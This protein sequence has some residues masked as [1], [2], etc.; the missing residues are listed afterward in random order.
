L[1]KRSVA[2]QLAAIAAAYKGY[3]IA[4]SGNPVAGHAILAEGIA[5]LEATEAAVRLCFLRALHAETHLM[6]GEMDEA[7]L[8][9]RDQSESGVLVGVWALPGSNRL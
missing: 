8:S 5:D 2:P 1:S 6:F 7:Q 4:C 9:V 3:V